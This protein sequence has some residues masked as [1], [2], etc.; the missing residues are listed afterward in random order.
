MIWVAALL[1]GT[2]MIDYQVLRNGAMVVLVADAVRTVHLAFI[3]HAPIAE[4][5]CPGEL[6]ARL[7]E[8]VVNL[9]DSLLYTLPCRALCEPLTY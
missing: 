3:H 9:L 8:T 6:P 1:I 5:E 7:I 2:N 4:Y